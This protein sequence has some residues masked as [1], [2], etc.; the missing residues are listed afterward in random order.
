MLQELNQKLVFETK[1]LEIK[2][3]ICAMIMHINDVETI[4]FKDLLYLFTLLN[5]PYYAFFGLIFSPT[6]LSRL[7]LRFNAQ[8]TPDIQS[9][10]Y[11]APPDFR[12]RQNYH[13]PQSL[14]RDVY[15][16]LI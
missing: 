8:K 5:K 16:F 15:S 6:Y 4:H 2:T 11:S 10:S 12:T 9:T 1:I 14:R 3:K 7:I 13:S